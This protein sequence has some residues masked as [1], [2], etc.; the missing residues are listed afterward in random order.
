MVGCL[1]S[2]IIEVCQ[3]LQTIKSGRCGS[4]LALPHSFGDNYMVPSLKIPN[5]QGF[6]PLIWIAKPMDIHCPI[7]VRWKGNIHGME[8]QIVVVDS[9]RLLVNCWWILVVKKNIFFHS[10]SWFWLPPRFSGV[11][12]GKPQ[13]FTSKNSGNLLSAAIGGTEIF[14]DSDEVG[15]FFAQLRPQSN[16][17]KITR[18]HSDPVIHLSLFGSVSVPLVLNLISRESQFCSETLRT[19]N[20]FLECPA[21]MHP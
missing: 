18:E 9:I 8:R 10:N 15:L 12:L 2:N 14:G 6:I 16:P 13:I 7:D 3:H 17:E 5:N 1:P 19:L 4:L 20:Q 11:F 21:W